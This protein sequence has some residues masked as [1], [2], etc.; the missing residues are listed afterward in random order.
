MKKFDGWS[1]LIKNKKTRVTRIY[2]KDDV[3]RDLPFM[4][5]GHTS[6]F[7]TGEDLIIIQT[8]RVETP[9]GE[10]LSYTM[11]METFKE[12]FIEVEEFY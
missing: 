7:L 3:E 10:Y 11:N 8:K 1:E 4:F 2:K 5:Y 6:D 12:N 9:N